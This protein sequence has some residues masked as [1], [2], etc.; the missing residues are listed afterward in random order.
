MTRVASFAVLL[1][2]L[3]V[4]GIVFYSV[5]S[6]FLLPLF[7][8]SFMVVVFRPLH[9]R[10]MAKMPGRR[11][12]G[13]AVT[14]AA[15]IL[16]VLLPV[17]GVLTFAGIESVR[18]VRELK[19][20][21]KDNPLIKARRAMGL[22]MPVAGE[23]RSLE[24]AVA[25]M[26]HEAHT[27]GH[28]KDMSS[29][30]DQFRRRTAALETRVEPEQWQPLQAEWSEVGQ[31][32]DAA[33]AAKQ[34]S[35]L[36]D[37]MQGLE[38][39]FHAFKIGLLGGPYWGYITEFVNPSEEALR[40]LTKTAVSS[41]QSLLLKATGATT[42][43]LSGVLF[44]ALITV[45]AF[46]FFLVDGP[47][48]VKSV[49]QLSPLDDEYEKELLHEFVG[50][51]RAVVLATLLAAGAQS[52]LAG[53]GYWVAGVE[54]VFLLTVLTGALAMI[55][56]VGA[57]GIWLPVCLYMFFVEGHVVTAV[58]L[59]VYCVGVVSTIDNVIKPYVLSGQSNLH[60]LLALLS[61]LGG[62]TTLGPIGI[63][64]GPTVVVL[65]RTL[66]NMLHRELSHFEQ[67]KRK[68][69]GLPAPGDDLPTDAVALADEAREK[70][71]SRDEAV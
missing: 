55:P 46:F 56:L 57:A 6:A 28:V 50:V 18:V 12:I 20:S 8:A 39:S 19:I 32:I 65:L 41:S 64:V 51:S 63:L 4:I 43:W 47:D 11:Y 33:A 53:L 59:T 35:Q 25:E 68:A 58:L 5:M 40:E 49:M 31:A 2:I 7:L 52:L 44:S 67:A 23:L 71:S 30:L 15:V 3:V 13:A 70:P 66:L 38:D 36:D 60:P 62:V 29:R 61:V 42:A 17:G 22:E 69:Q 21:A 1:V 54:A 34:A 27:S 45:I 16:I 14:T 24:K 48:M 26:A 10:L 9:E 37:A